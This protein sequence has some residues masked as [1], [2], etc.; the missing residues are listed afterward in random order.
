MHPRHWPQQPRKPNKKNIHYLLDEFSA[1]D[2]KKW[3]DAKDL[4]LRYHWE[5]YSNL[6]FQ[7]SRIS[8]EIKQSLLEAAAKNYTITRWQRIVKHKF[9]VEPLSVK[10]SLSDPGGRFNIGEINPNQYQIFP[11]LYIASNKE[12]ALQEALSQHI[13]PGKEEEALN[14]ALTNTVSTSNI[15]ISGRIDSYIDLNSPERLKPFINLFKDFKIPKHVYEIAKYFKFP[16]PPTVITT[17]S[18]LM[19]ALLAPNWREWPMQYDVPVASQIFGQ[20]VMA[21]GI[22]GILYPSKFSKKNCLVI[23]PQN[24][25]DTNGSLIQLDDPAPKETKVLKWDHA[26]WKQ[27]GTDL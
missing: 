7:R 6:A 2:I 1:A 21:A 24:F 10:G 20:L 18:K 5:F 12:T 8:D 15:S 22:E 4:L 16:E 11:A 17:I 3:G 13:L 19:E 27:F 26:T 9:S 14:S 23:Y 25:D